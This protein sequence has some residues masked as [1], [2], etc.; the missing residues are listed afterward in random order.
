[1]KN[2]T[3][4][5][6]LSP[7]HICKRWIKTLENNLHVIW[8]YKDIELFTFVWGSRCYTLLCRLYLALIH[9]SSVLYAILMIFIQI[10]NFCTKTSRRTLYRL[11][12]F[13]RLCGSRGITQVDSHCFPV[14][15]PE[16]Q[17]LFLSILCRQFWWENSEIDVFDKKWCEKFNLSSIWQMKHLWWCYNESNCVCLSY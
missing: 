14:D 6:F 16:D 17:E 8:N 11:N 10:V 5:Q 12:D 9:S 15:I 3:F 2:M 1:M 7:V 4:W 13:N